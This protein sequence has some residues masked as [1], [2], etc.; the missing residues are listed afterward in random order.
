MKR[1]LKPLT[2]IALGALLAIPVLAPVNAAQAAAHP[3]PRPADCVAV[4]DAAALRAVGQTDPVGQIAVS[5]DPVRFGP[6]R[7][8]VD[9]DE[10][11]GGERAVDIKIDRDCNVL[12]VTTTIE[13]DDPP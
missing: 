11:P 8:R 12:S 2:A 13:S 7:L 1:D 6:N 4:V 3:I 9:V 5:G 10:F